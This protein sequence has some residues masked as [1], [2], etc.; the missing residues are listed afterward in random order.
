MTELEEANLQ[1]TKLT[2]KSLP[3]ERQH[4][5]LQDL[6]SWSAYAYANNEALEFN[7]SILT[8]ADLDAQAKRFAT[9]LRARGVGRGDFVVLYMPRGIEMFIGMLGIIEAGAVYVPMDPHSPLERVKYV[10]KDSQAKFIVTTSSQMKPDFSVACLYFDQIREEMNKVEVLPST[11]LVNDPNDLAYVIYTSGSTGQ[12]KGVM[13]R[14]R[15]IAHFVHSEGSV[16]DIRPDDKVLQGF[17][18]SFDM[19]LEEIWTAFYAGAKLIIASHEW[20]TSGPELASIINNLGITVWHCVPT[21]LAMQN[22]DMPKVR[23]INLGGEACPAHLVDRWAC[24]GRRLLNTYG[25]TETT[26]SAT[27]AEL[28]AHVPVTI[29]KAL[30]GYTTYIVDET[31]QLVEDGKE[32]ELCI[33]GPGLAAGYM[34]RPDLT[35][36]KFVTAPFKDE[37]DNP[38]FIYRTGD[39][40]RYNADKDIEFLGRFDTQIKIRGFRVELSEIE[41]VLM[42]E[43][44]VQTAIVALLK[45][46]HGFDALV[47]FVILQS[48]STFQEARAWQ[49]LRAK[50]PL[51]MVP[52][53]M[54]FVEELPRLPSG[55]VDRKQLRFPERALAEQKQKTV[56]APTTSMEKK[57][58]AVWTEL[59]APLA[60]SI[61]D[62]FFLD[63]GGHSLRAALMVSKLRKDHGLASISIQAVYKNRS[64]ASL[65]SFLEAKE[66][67]YEA[68]DSVQHEFKMIPRLRYALC[69]LAQG[70][71]LGLLFTILSTM[72][73]LPYLVYVTSSERGYTILQ[74][75]VMSFAVVVLLLPLT[76]VLSILAKWTLIGKYKEG[77]YPLWG[78]YYVR[79][80]L[81][82]RFHS[83]VPSSF[84]TGTPLLAMY[85]RLMGAHVGKHVYL[86]TSSC[87]TWDLV[88]IGDGSV[89]SQ[90]A[91][92]CCSSVEG[93][94]LKIRSIRVGRSCFVGNNAVLAMGSTMEDGSQLEDLSLL[95]PHRRIPSKEQW[96][97]SPARLNTR[98][99]QVSA[100][101]AN[102]IPLWMGVLQALTAATLPLLALLPILP[103]L[104]WLLTRHENFSLSLLAAAPVL[105]LSYIVLSCLLIVAMKW[106]LIGKLKRSDIPFTSLAYFRFWLASRLMD[107]SLS[108]VRPIYET[109]YLAPWFRMLGVRLGKRTEVST[110]RGIVWDL[111]DISDECFVASGVTL[112]VA[113]TWNGH[114]ELRPTTIGRRTFLGNSALVPGG[115]ELTDNMLVGCLSVPPSS[116]QQRMQSGTS[117]FGS[118]AIYLPQRQIFSNF[119]ESTTFNPPKKLYA[120]RL[121]IEFFRIIL[122]AT[123]T[124]LL[125]FL[126]IFTI[127]TLHTQYSLMHLIAA[128][129]FLFVGYGIASVLLT[130]LIKKIL[131]QSY[132]PTVRP[133]WSHFVWRSELVTTL[134]ENFPV[135]AFLSHLRGTGFLPIFL[136][137]LGVKI[138]K[139]A[140]METTDITE[141]DVVEMGD[142]VALNDNCG[143]QTH[144][145]EERIMKVSKVTLGDR[146]SV[147]AVAIVLYDAVMENDSQLGDLSMLMKGETLPIGTHW[148]GL[149][150]QRVS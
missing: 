113:R 77:D 105:A 102:K 11:E 37:H 35:Q 130:A 74:S 91:S 29:G 8:Y 32:G 49:N 67:E 53:L 52:A 66:A 55:K 88:S 64:V 70:G 121:F 4:E 45:D 116:P 57:I 63:L 38:I 14:H 39:L 62:D 33:G 27:Y 83:L 36:E 149:P 140:Y 99:D 138:G 72:G 129:P 78:S 86:N 24:N 128:L 114:V 19:S 115:S 119:D 40:V 82:K 104:F 9:Y 131:M 50:L 135:P 81:V 123:L 75:L 31:L 107:L 118:P 42:Q 143:L 109:L 71:S 60:V 92:F 44:G 106:T 132:V 120:V 34:N 61:D 25:P 15:S 41:S 147:G 69:M 1:S 28:K 101:D 6:F 30:P 54:D 146:C 58:H 136:R 68:K 148:E 51:Y 142:D 141:F 13:I 3:L 103:G 20:M 112:G 95:S 59:F 85:Y 133:L 96:S 139:R 47:A 93:G 97:G 18:L 90:G 150:A 10:Y 137:V 125:S 126:T 17:S 56:K 89:I 2:L 16:L 117:W 145:F 98:V 26:V 12:P 5:T 22:E 21:L 108:Y 127:Y 87:D 94:M 144:L 76:F 7:G 122:P 84:L 43:P 80:W 100:V 46:Q 79:W 124:I 65:A 110:A 134:Y 48:K 23:L 111:L 73:V